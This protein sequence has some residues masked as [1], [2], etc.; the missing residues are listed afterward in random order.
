MVKPRS[1]LVGLRAAVSFLTPVGGAA[2]PQPAAIWWFPA[3]GAA[4]G[5]S[6]GGVWWV[7]GHW[8]PPAV[9][10]IVA[11]IADLALTGMLHFDGLCDA[12]DGL[13]PHLTTERRMEVMAAPDVGAFGVAVATTTLLAR[14]AVLAN[15]HPAPLL[16]A[17][18]WAASRTWMAITLTA[19]PYARANGGLASAFL[20][21]RSHWAPVAIGGMAL[22]LALAVL[23]RP[24][25]GPAAI[26]SGAAAAGAVVALAYRRI[27]GFTGDVLGAAGVVG[28]TV[29]L[30]VAAARW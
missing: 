17:G 25:V 29:G 22:A 24:G 4:V 2:V 19:V 7:A 13:L 28:E 27:G 6:V 18:L 23:W 20:D 5:F 14:W 1:S 10:A 11:V 30:L 21:R 8:W 3:V 15:L 26:A 12:A 16:V 9:A